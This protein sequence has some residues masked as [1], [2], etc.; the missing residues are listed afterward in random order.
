MKTCKDRKCT[1]SPGSLYPCLIA[2]P[3]G[4]FLL[5]PNL[6]LVVTAY[7]CW[8]FP[9]SWALPCKAW[10]C[11]SS[12]HW[13][14]WRCSCLLDIM[15][16]MW[17]FVWSPSVSR[18][19]WYKEREMVWLHASSFWEQVWYMLCWGWQGQNNGCSIT[20]WTDCNSEIRRN[21]SWLRS[22]LALILQDAKAAESGGVNEGETDVRCVLK[23]H[24]GSLSEKVCIL[25][26]IFQLNF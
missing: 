26:V 12:Q 3:L 10:F 13:F 4:Q 6:Q 15:M 14:T 17:I 21:S 1:P 16:P 8:P 19:T 18:W 23:L 11:C 20:F 9:S 7:A 25:P 24:C 2:L 22:A 5:R